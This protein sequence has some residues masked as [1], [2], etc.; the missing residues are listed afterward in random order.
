MREQLYIAG[1]ERRGDPSRHPD[2]DDA[3]ERW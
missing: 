2:I 3:I 1:T